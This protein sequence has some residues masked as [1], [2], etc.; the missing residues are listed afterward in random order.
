M[1][2]EVLYFVLTQQFS[3]CGAGRRPT[4]IEISLINI[5]NRRFFEHIV[6][7]DRSGMPKIPF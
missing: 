4:A 1:A 7:G 2:E 6:D 3:L 5:I